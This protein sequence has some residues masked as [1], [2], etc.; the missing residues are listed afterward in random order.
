MQ[1]TEDSGHFYHPLATF[2]HDTQFS[3]VL[4]VTPVKWNTSLFLLHTCAYIHTVHMLCMTQNTTQ[5]ALTSN[6][7]AYKRNLGSFALAKQACIF[8]H[9][10]TQRYSS[11]NRNNSR[12]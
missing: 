1:G 11:V 2:F 5:Q 4:P 9:P 8:L 6:F 3:K 12:I 7:S 10:G